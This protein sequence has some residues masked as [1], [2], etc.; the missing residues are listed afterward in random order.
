MHRLFPN[1][2]AASSSM[3]LGS[4]E[5]ISGAYFSEMKQQLFVLSAS[6]LPVGGS[7]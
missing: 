6:D 2:T 1:G 3:S 4:S 5:R 7:R